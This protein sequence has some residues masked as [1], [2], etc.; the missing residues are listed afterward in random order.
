[1]VAR[2]DISINIALIISIIGGIIFIAQKIQ[3]I[4][5]N[6][7]LETIQRADEDKNREDKLL[8]VHNH[9][10]EDL[11]QLQSEVERLRADFSIPREKKILEDWKR[12]K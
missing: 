3:K 5:D 10:A 4:E 7:I 11:K 1:M 2:I 6:I 9:L 12:N 8:I